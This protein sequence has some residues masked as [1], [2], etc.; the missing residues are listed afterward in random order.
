MRVTAEITVRD[1]HDRTWEAVVFADRD[2]YRR[3]SPV[4]SG[5]LVGNGDLYSQDAPSSPTTLRTFPRSWSPACV[6]L[7]RTRA[8]YRKKNRSKI[9]VLA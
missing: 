6:Q 9:S 1:D 7:Q 2:A 3:Y 5:N 4:C 8:D